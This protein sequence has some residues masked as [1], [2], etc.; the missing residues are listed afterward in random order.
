[1]KRTDV[2]IV[3][4]GCSGLYCALQL[5]KDMQ[6]LM[7]S[8]SDLESSDSFLAQGGMCTLRSDDDFE[9]FFQ[10]TLKAG[11]YEND[12]ESVKIMIQ[13]SKAV[14]EDLLSYGTE[15]DRDEEGNLL[16]T[17]EGAHSNNRI[18]FHEDITGK[19]ITS[20]LLG[21][22]RERSNI[23]LMEYT[24]M[25]DI[26]E[27][28]NRCFGAVLRN[29]DG[30]VEP[31]LAKTTV[32]AC[33][34]V[35]GLFPHSTNFKHLTGDTLALAQKHGVALRNPD[36]VQ[37]HPTTLYQKGSKER[38]FLIS[39]SVRG[40]G[41]KLYDKNGNRFVDELLPRDLLT[42]AILEQM[43]KDKTDYVWEDLRTIPKEELLRHFPNIVEHCKEMGYDVT[44]ECI[45][46]VPAQHYYMGGIKVNYSSRTTMEALY[47]VGEAACNGVHGRN[48]LASNSL[49]ESLVFAKRAAKDIEKK[50]ICQYLPEEEVHELMLPME[51]YLQGEKLEQ[52]YREIALNALG[53]NGKSRSKVG[54][55]SFHHVNLG[56]VD[57]R[58]IG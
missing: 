14:V 44:K 51:E 35:G 33:G 1:M 56:K 17:R 37:I 34:G 18:L 13:S 32:W 21:K 49:L 11:H 38:S 45:P 43:E 26:L 24:T 3:G 25:I 10:D 57:S 58:K 12:R 41:A 23:T 29:E 40:E 48:R 16:Y 5:P 55:I 53:Q 42:K 15:F 30:S 31:V 52:E 22:V 20:S 8:K 19:E 50:Q 28:D 2:L 47:A 36:Y 54:K 7:I 27:K 4:T 6:I 39:E 9:S 46:V